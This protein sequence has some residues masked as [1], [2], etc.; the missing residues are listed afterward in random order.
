VIRILRWLL[1][2]AAPLA[3]LAPSVSAGAP[4]VST[5]PQFTKLC[6]VCHGTDA[7]GTDRGP[8]LVNNRG[9]R[10]RSESDIRNLIRNG[11]PSGMP[12]FALPE[13]ELQSLARYV[14]SLNASAFEAK[15]A[16]D[17]AA[18]ELFFFGK[19]QCASCH[20]VRGQG[21]AN[22]P[23]LSNIGRQLTLPELEQSL[24]EPSAR[25]AEGW[26]VVDAHLR[27]GRL[28]RGFARNQGKRNLQL[29]TLDGRL[30]FLSDAEL[31]EVSRQKNSTMPPVKAAPR[32]YRDLVAYLSGLNG[33][34]VGPLTKEPE[35]ISAEAIQRIL[36]A[37][38]GEWPTY[39]SGMSATARSIR[40]IRG[41]SASCICSGPT[42]SRI[43]VSR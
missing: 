12:A 20:M 35:P 32:E 19:G 37:Q 23:D 25:I 27:D 7:S 9:L 22:G 14:R 6:A 31:A 18:G 16:G 11:T 41:T 1:I 33:V 21:K 39:Y 4:V 42:R 26:A 43:S 17:A 15:P 10:S 29:Q 30:H 3:G 34:T 40:S 13:T 5:D 24:N 38:P 8:A 36:H 2:V 28:L